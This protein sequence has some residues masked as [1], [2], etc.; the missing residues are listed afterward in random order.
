[1]TQNLM[2]MMIQKVVHTHLQHEIRYISTDPSVKD[3]SRYLANL[4]EVKEPDDISKDKQ[5]ADMATANL[6]ECRSL[7]KGE[8]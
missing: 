5:L 8:R 3:V 6:S 2:I 7:D 1:M 4:K